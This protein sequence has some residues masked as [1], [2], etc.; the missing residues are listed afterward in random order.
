MCVSSETPGEPN[1][2]T[3]EIQPTGA[4]AESSDKFKKASPSAFPLLLP[5]W[6]RRLSLECLKNAR[7]GFA[8]K[9]FKRI[10][11]KKFL[12]I[13]RLCSLADVSVP[14]TYRGTKLWKSLFLLS[15]VG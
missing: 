8:I 15:H 3:P 10:K 2:N 11:K 5:C 12:P 14:S 4:G 13:T 7:G 6:K 9:T 1:L